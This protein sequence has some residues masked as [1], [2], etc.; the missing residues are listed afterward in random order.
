[1]DGAPPRLVTDVVTMSSVRDP[2]GIG[3]YAGA[4]F[5]CHIGAIPKIFIKFK[6]ILSQKALGIA[7]NSFRPV[8]YGLFK[9]GEK[10][11]GDC[12]G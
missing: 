4:R 12:C 11:A 7:N 10:A 9:G 2:H 6:S 8:C 1:M 3:A 5:V